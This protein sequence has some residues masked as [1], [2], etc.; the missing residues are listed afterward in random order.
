M[1]QDKSF[2]PTVRM[3]PVSE[4][5]KGWPDTLTTMNGN[6][7]A[8]ISDDGKEKSIVQFC[9]KGYTVTDN[10]EVIPEIERVLDGANLKYTTKHRIWNKARF[11]FQYEITNL[12]DVS[13]GSKKDKLRPMISVNNS[14]DGG[15]KFGFDIGFMRLV[16]SNGM[17]VPATDMPNL[18]VKKMHTASIRDLVEGDQIIETVQEFSSKA[19]DM[20]GVFDALAGKEFNLDELEERVEAVIKK[21]RFPSR[22]SELVI[23]RFYQ[24][25]DLVS[26]PANDWLLFNAFN[27]TL[28]HEL[29]QPFHKEAAMDAKVL[30]AI[31]SI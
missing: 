19:Q 13:V 10:K 26:Q 6:S 14:Y 7:H 25:L 16:C 30:E 1:K 4:L 8:I 15:L 29:S 24:E 3:V 11:K 2:F 9:S 31:Q 18:K 20:T 22:Q 27:G 12:A 23:N 21:T 28:Q 17:T 5:T